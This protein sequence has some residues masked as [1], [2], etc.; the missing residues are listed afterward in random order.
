MLAILLF[1]CYRESDVSVVTTLIG[2]VIMIGCKIAYIA[3]PVFISEAVTYG[4]IFLCPFFE[5]EI[6]SAH[7]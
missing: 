1:P 5:I 4:G 3:I 2:D 6:G 7:P